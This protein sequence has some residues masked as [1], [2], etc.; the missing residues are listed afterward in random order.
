MSGESD[1]TG[2][3]IIP[4][5]GDRQPASAEGQGPRTDE[6]IIEGI[7][8]CLEDIN[9]GF[10]FS[11]L[12]ILDDENAVP[13]RIESLKDQLGT[14]VSARLFIIANSVH[15]GKV[16]SG[17][18]TKFVD[19]VKH[20]GTEAT[21]TTAIFIALHSLASTKELRT[22]FARNFSTSKL[23][24]VIAR[25]LDLKGKTRSMVTLGGL[26]I[27]M[28]KVFILLYADKE[29]VKLEDEF[30]EQYYPRVGA[31]VIERFRLPPSL[32][33]IID[34]THFT[35]E[36]KESLSLSAIVDM[37]HAVVDQSFRKHGKLVVESVMPDPEGLVY[38]STIGSVLQGQFQ[39]MDL[40]EFL[41]V[42]PIEYSEQE[43]RLIEKGK[44]T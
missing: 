5:Q 17:N 41:S 39:S 44:A 35:F 24:D 25:H 9:L 23:T 43:K 11:V 42:I 10:D 18:I 8:Q 15:Y 2:N 28:G 27:E 21:K 37:A 29:D 34:H 26:F 38:T 7:L 3:K 1:K 40:G 36:K 14:V 32:I 31:K 4:E 20:L 12:D 16:R 6:E 33:G 19:V 22:I 13:S 30:I